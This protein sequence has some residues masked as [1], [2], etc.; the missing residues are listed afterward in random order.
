MI[1]PKKRTSQISS[2]E[3]AR[4]IANLAI[5]KKADNVLLLDV[6]QQTPIT[7]FFLI[8]SGTT[9]VQVKAIFDTILYELDPP[10]KPWHV[11]GEEI[12]KWILMDFVD[13]VVHIFQK[14]EREFYQ[15]ERLWA[16]A[17]FEKF[18]DTLSTP[19]SSKK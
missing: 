2:K 3:L 17:H 18:E 10:V 9:D 7:D 6:R 19:D 5:S 4:K 11:E 14:K 15:L 1:T 8:C 16:D 13:V 12:R